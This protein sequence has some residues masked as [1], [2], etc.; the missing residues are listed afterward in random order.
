M[1]HWKGPAGWVVTRVSMGRSALL[2]PRQPE[3]LSAVIRL[4]ARV[5]LVDRQQRPVDT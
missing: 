3:P 5:S 4:A 1:R 2:F